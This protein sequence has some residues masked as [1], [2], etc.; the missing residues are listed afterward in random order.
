[1]GRPALITRQSGSWRVQSFING[2][3]AQLRQALFMPALV[4][5]RSNPPLK[6]KYPALRKPAKVAIVAIM[7]KLIVIANALLRDVMWAPELASALGAN[8]HRHQPSVF[9]FGAQLPS[10]LV[11]VIA[12]GTRTAL[13]IAST[14]PCRL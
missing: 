14:L 9:W 4:A 13:T 10:R 2:G 12:L 6:A 3:R 11:Q 7:R 8:Q 1:L 5:I